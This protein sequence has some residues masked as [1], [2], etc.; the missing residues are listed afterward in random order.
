MAK[1]EIRIALIDIDKMRI[2]EVDGMVLLGDCLRCGECC[3]RLKCEEVFNETLDYRDH[4]VCRVY[5]GRPISCALW[6]RPGDPQPEGCGFRYE[7]KRR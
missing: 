1:D 3:L 6:P 2:I 4:Y 7:E 5:R